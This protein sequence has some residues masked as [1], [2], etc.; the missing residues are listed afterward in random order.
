M[1]K[2]IEALTPIIMKMIHEGHSYPEIAKELGLKNERVIRNLVYRINHPK[3]NS[4]P[5]K[6]GR[7]PKKN[8]QD[9]NY[10]IKRLKME[11]Q[12]LRDFLL[13]IRKEWKPL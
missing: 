2:K 12:L 4:L 8:S 3:E 11:N 6:R 10:E 7:K 9:Y 5:K 13:L 1:S